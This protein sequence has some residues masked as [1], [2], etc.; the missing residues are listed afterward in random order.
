M[1]RVQKEV[2]QGLKVR[3]D[4]PKGYVQRGKDDEGHPWSRIYLF[5]YGFLPKTQGGDGD[6]LD[7][8]L[9]P[10]K[11]AK[12]AYWAVQKKA[13]GSF[14]EYKVFLG[15][16]SLAAAKKAYLA[17]IPAKFLDSFFEVEIPVMRSLLGEDP[18][19]K[20]AMF[21]AFSDELQKIAAAQLL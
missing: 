15:F 19:Q 5:D 7:V 18:K 13:D 14:D 2:F 20:V 11:N 21:V 3:I 9:G 8:F 17:H 6:G 1:K 4:R 16:E 12:K 10:K